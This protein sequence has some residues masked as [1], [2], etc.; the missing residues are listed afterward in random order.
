MTNVKKNI[1]RNRLK[2]TFRKKNKNLRTSSI[3]NNKSKYKK[4]KQ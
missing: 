2:S 3:K 4:K 1:K